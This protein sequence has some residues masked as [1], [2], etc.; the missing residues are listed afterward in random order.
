[1]KKIYIVTE[2]DPSFGKDTFSYTSFEKAKAKFTEIAKHLFDWFEVEIDDED[3]ELEECI[4]DWECNFSDRYV[5]ID[6][7]YLEE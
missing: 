6:E 3:R 2:Y 5:T 4:A 7:S 1:M